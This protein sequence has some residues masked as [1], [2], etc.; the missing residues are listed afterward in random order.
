MEHQKISNLLNEANN[1]KFV[2]RK[3]N[4]VNDNSRTNYDAGSETIYN[5]E[6]LKSNI[7]DYNDAHISVRG[8]ISIIGHQV[9]QVAFKNCA[10]FIKYITKI[11]GTTID[12]AE[13]L[14]LVMLIYSL[15]EY[16]SIYSETTGSLVSFKDKTTGFNA[17]IA[18]TNEFKFFMCKNK[19]LENTLADGANGI[20]KHATIIVPFKYRRSLEILLMNCKVEL[21]LKRSKYCVLSP[22][23]ADN[24]NNRDSNNIIFTIKDTKLYVPVLTLSAKYNQKL[25]KLLSK[26]SEISIFW[27][28]YK[29]KSDNKN[30]TN[31]FRFFR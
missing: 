20:L 12:D 30:T 15:I 7:C 25:S 6:I 5:T 13:D 4:I 1:S 8:N 9:T 3:W 21:K 29:T 26:G 11:D 14:V 23:G 24:I 19:L 17:D 27:N 28:E 22:A 16:S 2:K 31:E 18:N 10:Q